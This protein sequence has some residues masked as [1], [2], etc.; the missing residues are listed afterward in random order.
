MARGKK[1]GSLYVTQAKLCKEEVNVTNADIE[2]WHRRLGHMSEKGLNILARKKSLLDM[3][4]EAVEDDDVDPKEGTTTSD[5]NNDETIEEE[6][7][8]RRST[9]GRIP[10]T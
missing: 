7:E 6:L 4:G 8:L 5:E 9:R 3:R 2:L 10:S 1:D